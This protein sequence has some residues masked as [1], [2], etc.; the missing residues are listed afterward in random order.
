MVGSAGDSRRRFLETTAR[1]LRE[2]G[3]SATSMGDVVAESGAPKGSLYFH[4]PNG[5]DQL[6]AEAMGNA[7]AE[8]CAL[9]KM[10]LASGPAR[11][12]L[13]AIFTFLGDELEGSD[14]RVGC[15]IGTVAAEA[16]DAP[17]VREKVRE[18]FETWESVIA[19][20]LVQSGVKKKRAAD[21]STFILSIVEGALVLAKAKK[22]VVPLETAKREIARILRA[23]EIS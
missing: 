16:P 23:E 2:R 7:G 10:A 1:L 20:R 4:F 6:V 8:T 3:Y 17:R 18:V 13:D 14:F 15:P 9:M 11:V 12:G 22:S 21:L 19:A 5:K